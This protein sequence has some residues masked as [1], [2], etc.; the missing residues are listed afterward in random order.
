[1]SADREAFLARLLETFRVEA[2][3]HLAAISNGIALLERD[4]PASKREAV[5]RVFRETH[6]LK[7]AA[8]A[9]NFASVE[10]LCHSLESLFA[11]LKSDR[12]AAA[13]ALY[14]L[15]HRATDRLAAMLASSPSQSADPVAAALA[16]ELDRFS[17]AG[18][19][20]RQPAPTATDAQRHEPVEAPRESEPAAPTTLRIGVARL[21]AILRQ[22][23][24]LL[25]PRQ[26]A[27]EHVAGLGILH[28]FI[29]VRRRKRDAI[30]ALPASIHRMLETAREHDGG[31]ALVQ[32]LTRLLAWTESEGEW[33][34][35]LD[36]RVAALT[37][38]AEK[39]DR[40]L[41][42][43]VDA[44]LGEVKEAQMLPF[45][46][47]VDALRRLVRELAHNE[48][49]EVALHVHGADIELDR[50]VLD[51]LRAP[52]HHLLRNAVDHGI[53]PKSER[54]RA[55]KPEVG[56]LDLRISHRN[57]RIEIA[58]SDDGAGI[59]PVSVG[60]SAAKLGL[61]SR[62]ELERMDD[63]ALVSFIFQSGLST[64]SMITQ[65]SGRGLGLAIV[66]E[67]VE[68]IGGLVNVRSAVGVGTTVTLDVPLTLA[69]FRGVV[70][71]IGD[72]RFV[73]PLAGVDRVA[74]VA[75]AD[76]RTV[77]NRE[78][79]TIDDRAVPFVQLAR[80][81]EINFV[82]RDEPTT[83]IVVLGERGSR[84]AFGVDDVVEEHEVLVRS[85]GS[86]LLRVR[87]VAGAT[88]LANGAI[89]PV[90]SVG[91]LLASA[92]HA[93][94]SR[95][96][97][98]DAA[99]ERRRSI[100]VVEDSITSRMLLKNILE[101]AG[102]DVAVAVDGID[103]ITALRSGGFDL[104]VSD[105]EM[106]RMDGFDLTAKI[107]SDPAFAALPVVL[108]TALESREHRERGIDVGANAYIV[109]SSFDQSNLLDVVRRLL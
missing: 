2:A 65:I 93:G 64:S 75:Q 107:R 83:R 34:K 19:S 27:S 17:A 96:E 76:I 33:L 59:D 62:E 106:P 66:R 103:G 73:V 54:E 89:V 26:A 4:D 6:S 42:Q 8:R 28:D 70:V 63:A 31:T 69:T 44:L 48:G 52:L 46:S 16:H 41:G 90:L 1:M 47:V 9:V 72:R 109:K 97:S 78:T 91:D 61:A 29:E 92:V 36:D 87:N 30:R 37:Q 67:K 53:E 88:V 108:V 94:T 22:S 35:E 71:A 50:R 25:G 105:V 98:L 100:L 82:R 81:L 32:S 102:Y 79:I 68:Q 101:A 55:G 74:R 43:A 20:S 57:N 13:P 84:I 5:E 11:A 14:A 58:L 12:I 49:K 15:A 86:Q 51:E 10:A 104:V 99:D 3:E 40:D 56:S 24:E 38:R 23:E 60:A 18:P 21:D 39:D 80:V 77:E 85:L 95:E 7:G 45:S